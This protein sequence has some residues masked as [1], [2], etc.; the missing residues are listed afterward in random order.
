MQQFAGPYLLQYTQ[1]VFLHPHVIRHQP[2]LQT[3]TL[4]ITPVELTVFLFIAGALIALICWA[5]Y[6]AVLCTVRYAKYQYQQ[7]KT[8]KTTYSSNHSRRNQD[9]SCGETYQEQTRMRT[10]SMWARLHYTFRGSSQNS[11]DAAREEDRQRLIS[12]HAV[13]KKVGYYEGITSHTEVER[14]AYGDGVS[15]STSSSRSVIHRDD[16]IGNCGTRR[17]SVEY[18]QSMV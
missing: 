6:I 12:N 15:E 11:I 8:R 1:P 13:G 5:C 17:W 3:R 9:S 14:Q 2:N 16:C 18:H 7:Y 10:P 4:S